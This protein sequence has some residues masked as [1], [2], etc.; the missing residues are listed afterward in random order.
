M[1]TEELEILNQT[2]KLVEEN[3]KILRRIRRGN[4]ISLVIRSIYW[5]IILGTAFGTYYFIQPYM[6]IITENFSSIKE[7][8]DSLKDVTKNI[9]TLPNWMG[10]QN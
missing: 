7:N 8:V 5:I 1:T 3:N 6:K 2:L 4:R 9:S 10:G